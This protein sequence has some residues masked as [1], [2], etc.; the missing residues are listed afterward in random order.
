MKVPF[1]FPFPFFRCVVVPVAAAALSSIATQAHALTVDRAA[2]AAAVQRYLADHGDF[3]LNEMDWPVDISAVD[4]RARGRAVLQ[5]P[6]LESLGLVASSD[7]MAMR[8]ERRDDDDPHPVPQPVAVRRYVPTPAGEA[9][10]REREIVVPNAAGDRVVRRRDLCAAHLALDEV[11]EWKMLPARP[12]DGAPEFVAT[13]TYVATPAPWSAAPAF[14]QVFPMAARVLDGSHALL[15]KQRFRQVD[16][17]WV[18]SGLA[19]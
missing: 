11:V 6:V 9:A 8:I 3:C 13:Y 10:M 4:E 16:G 19:D 14:R 2:A 15:L 1:A 12:D 17:A 18:P 5:M 7:A